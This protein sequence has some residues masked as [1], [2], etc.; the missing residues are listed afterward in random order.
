MALRALAASGEEFQAGRRFV[1]QLGLARQ[2]SIEF[3][4]KRTHFARA[5]V[6]DKGRGDVIVGP[7]RG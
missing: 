6:G 1:R 4:G 3:R 7:I 2:I 5:F